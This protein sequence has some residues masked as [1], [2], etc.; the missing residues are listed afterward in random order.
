[1]IL[2]RSILP[3]GTQRNRHNEHKEKYDTIKRDTT[4]Q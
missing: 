2:P 4:Q 1:M 3:Q